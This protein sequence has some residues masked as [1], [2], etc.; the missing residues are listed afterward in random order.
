MSTASQTFPGI[1]PEDL[2]IAEG[3]SPGDRIESRIARHESR[4]L[5]ADA[6]KFQADHARKDR[7]APMRSAGTGAMGALD[8]ETVI[9]AQNVPFS[10][11]APPTG[12]EGRALT[13]RSHP[14]QE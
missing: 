6:L 1:E 10:T 8:A 14:E 13:P 4:S 7:R 2:R 11:M 5:D 3:K 9:A 12:C